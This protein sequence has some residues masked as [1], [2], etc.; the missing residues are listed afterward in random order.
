MTRRVFAAWFLYKYLFTNFTCLQPLRSS[1][2][3]D[4]KLF[5][6]RRIVGCCIVYRRKQPAGGGCRGEEDSRRRL[7]AALC[8]VAFLLLYVWPSNKQPQSECSSVGAIRVRYAVNCVPNRAERCHRSGA[9]QRA[10]GRQHQQKQ[11]D[12]WRHYVCAYPLAPHRV[13][14]Y[15]DTIGNGLCGGKHQHTEYLSTYSLPSHHAAC[16]LKYCKS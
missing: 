3:F 9:E 4:S 2:I 1:S 14:K 16:T 12:E 8:V 10:R 7:Q 5:L 15:C 13:E 6:T 11:H